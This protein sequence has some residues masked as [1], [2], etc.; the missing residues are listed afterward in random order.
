MSQ[1]PPTR[2]R[3]FQFGLR[4]LFW[5]MIVVALV[6]FAAN[7]RRERIRERAA[8]ESELEAKLHD[9]RIEA[10][11][12]MLAVNA[13]RLEAIRS[14]TAKAITDE[15]QMNVMHQELGGFRRATAE[16]ST[17]VPNPSAAP[18]K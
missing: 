14:L 12:Q 16:Q 5:L 10:Q 13:A 17:P 15:K 11:K 1:A 6:L 18:I 8:Y 9:A 2:R 3:W 7:E 4:E